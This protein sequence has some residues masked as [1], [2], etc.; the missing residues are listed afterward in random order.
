MGSVVEIRLDDQL[1]FFRS[2]SIKSEEKLKALSWLTFIIGGVGTYLAATGHQI[3][4]ALTTALVTAIGS[5]LGYK[6]VESTLTK[7]NQAATDFAN[8]KAWWVALSAEE[9]SRQEN[10]DSLVEHTE[11]VLESELDGWVQQM[12]NALA[13]LR[14]D[15]E[16]ATE[17]K[18]KGEPQ[19]SL[20]PTDAKQPDAND[21]S[22]NEKQ[23]P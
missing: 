12:Q 17:D 14:K 21:Q 16:P 10:I 15:Q 9:Q 8:V 6:Q 3:W 18:E 1:S 2:K 4:I 19:E 11:Q 22:P 20:P 5:Y 13:E 7:Y 23:L